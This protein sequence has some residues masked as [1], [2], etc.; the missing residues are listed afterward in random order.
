MMHPRCSLIGAAC[1]VFASAAC[2]SQQ[3][4]SF[5]Y[6]SSAGGPTPAHVY[7]VDVNNDGISDIV[8]DNSQSGS[9]FTVSISNGDGTFKAPVTYTINSTS[10]SPTPIATGDFNGDGKVDIAVSLAGTTKVA[11]YLGNGDGTFQAAKTTTIGLPSG[12][13]IPATPIV[14]ADYNHDGKL[15]LVVAT[16]DGGT[17]GVYLLEGDG[18]GGF[19]D[20]TQIYQPTSGWEVQSLVIG[21]FDTDGNADVG[22]LEQMPCSGGQP[23]CSSNVVALFGNGA[24]SFDAVDVTT[25]SGAMNLGSGDVNG[26]GVTDLWGIEY[27]SNQLSNFLGNYDRKF[28]YY[29]TP[30]PSTPGLTPGP[31]VL[32][33]YQE[34]A[35]LL[36]PTAGSTEKPEWLWFY[37][38]D[39]YGTGGTDPYDTLLADVPEAGD[40]TYPW[41]AGPVVGAFNADM[42]MDLMVAGS[43]SST[44]TTSNYVTGLNDTPFFYGVNG[45]CGLPTTSPSVLLCSPSTQTT[46]GQLQLEQSY[47]ETMISS[48]ATSFGMI[49]KMEVW[50][51]GK[52]LGEDHTAVGPTAWIAWYLE[53]PAVGTHSGTIYEADIDNT[54]H[55]NDFTFTVGSTCGVLPDGAYGVNV[56]T[57]AVDGTYANPVQVIA[58]AKIT[59]TLA[60]ME[61]WVDGQKMYTETNSTSLNTTLT[62]SDADHEFDIY[63][64]NT[65][66]QKWETTVYANAN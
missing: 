41:Y 43:S 13:V 2:F 65:A 22:V 26:D 23:G 29:Y 36:L 33:P 3:E 52:K 57:P 6:T 49:R 48:S 16:Q 42:A 39:N 9:S 53:T 1:A 21:D 37:I 66:G 62:L 54:L 60:R 38:Y 20:P 12:T 56:C 7:A 18:T 44:S 24:T 59:G 51:D 30:L 25:V 35:T 61:V 11:V 50:I 8:A 28:S 64:V 32:M 10:K 55:R 15:D 34:M 19:T 45:Y 40:T 31:V 14:A 27:S 47:G 17:W 4:L 58:T 5:S 46:S 63:A